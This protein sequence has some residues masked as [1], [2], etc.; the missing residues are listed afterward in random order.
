MLKFGYVFVKVDPQILSKFEVC[1]SPF[2]CWVV[3]FPV[4]I[5]CLGFKAQG[6]DTLPLTAFLG[7]ALAFLVLSEASLGL[8]QAFPGLAL[9]SQGL[10]LVFQGLA[11][12]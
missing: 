1:T 7:L 9:A 5:W 12:A 3:R 10:D 8:A 11:R 6:I 4:C 2:V